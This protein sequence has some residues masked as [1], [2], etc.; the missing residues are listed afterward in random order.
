MS[1]RSNAYSQWWTTVLRNPWLFGG[2]LL[3]ITTL[4]KPST[5]RDGIS[6]EIVIKQ[7]KAYTD[8]LIRTIDY[9]SQLR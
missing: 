6:Q 8:E 2:K 3:P 7:D 5:K 9:V 1:G 4:I